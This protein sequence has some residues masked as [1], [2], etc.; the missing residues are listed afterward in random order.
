MKKALIACVLIAGILVLP[1]LYSTAKGHTRWYWR[2]PNGM[3]FVDGRP[4]PGYIH[5]SKQ[6]IL[7]TRR[8]TT[9]PHSY[10]VFAN[11]PKSFVVD[12]GDWAAPA[13]FV[14]PVGDVNPPC[15]PT[16][17]ADEPNPSS[18]ESAIG[19]IVTQAGSVEFHTKGGKLIRVN[20]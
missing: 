18:A 17:S 12:C 5:Q 10:E 7:V 8:D 3:V 19:S 15:L 20:Y 9:T 6:V 16:I 2:K 1:I 13:F 11:G 4:V 14:F